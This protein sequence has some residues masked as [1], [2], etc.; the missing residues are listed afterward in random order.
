MPPTHMKLS[1]TSTAH[2][3]GTAL[4]LDA[5][6]VRFGFQVDHPWTNIVWHAE[7]RIGAGTWISST[8]STNTSTSAA[9]LYNI[10]FPSPVTQCRAVVTGS[11]GGT[12][13]PATIHIAAN[14]T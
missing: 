8:G 7:G 14:R 9:L 5:G 11:A 3:A 4:Y 13:A 6:N 10:T 1:Y 2:E 12:T